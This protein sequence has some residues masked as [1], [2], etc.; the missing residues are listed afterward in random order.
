M[1]RARLSDSLAAL[2]V[3]LPPHLAAIVARYETAMTSVVH[4]LRARGYR[5]PYAAS[6]R[7]RRLCVHFA[8]QLRSRGVL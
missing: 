2:G 5:A 1:A 4:T 8:S 6:Y 3:T 7:A